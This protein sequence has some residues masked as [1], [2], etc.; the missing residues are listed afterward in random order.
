MSVWECSLGYFDDW[1]KVHHKW[2]IDNLPPEIAD[3]FFKELQT[4]D[5]VSKQG[6]MFFHLLH[7]STLDV[8]EY[9]YGIEALEVFQVAV[10]LV[11]SF[12]AMI[13]GLAHNAG[14]EQSLHAIGLANAIMMKMFSSGEEE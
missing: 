10:P 5:N 12:N 1:S 6:F 8:S 11:H 13:M 9:P 7:M 4:L 14:D 3:S 2:M